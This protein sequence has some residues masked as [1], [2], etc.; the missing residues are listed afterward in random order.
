M[1]DNI[2]SYYL[3]EKK[4]SINNIDISIFGERVNPEKLVKLTDLMVTGTV[5]GTTAKPMLEEMFNTGKRA[6]DIVR[7]RGLGQISDTGEIESEV[8]AVLSSNSQAVAD[9]RE[10]KDQALKF[11]I[12]QVM[13]ATRGRAN[14]QMV[15]EVLQRKLKEG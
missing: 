9:Y 11:L 1:I 15:N 3:T 5:S 10:G 6:E 8:A 2:Q 13:K 12:G 4:Y 7:E 14:P